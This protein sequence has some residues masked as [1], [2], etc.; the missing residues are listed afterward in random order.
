VV[1]PNN[2]PTETANQRLQRMACEG[3]DESRLL[4]SRRG[5]LGVTAG[6]FSWAF[7]PR[8]AEASSADPRLVVVVLRG[9]MD[10][11]TTVVPVGDPQ[12]V[13]KRGALA[14][15]AAS[16]IRLNSF[17]GLH[18]TLVN[19]GKFYA[20]GDA[21]VVHAT[22]VPFHN[23]SHF[24]GQDNLESGLPGLGSNETGWLNRL[25][26]ALPAGAPI[27]TKGAIEIGR[28]PLILRGPAPV[29]GWSPSH[30]SHM[31]D[32]LLTMVRTLYKAND[33]EL[34]TVLDRGLKADNLAEG[35]GIDD[36]SESAMILGFRGAGR[37]VASPTGPRIAV[38]SVDGWDTHLNQG[39]VD[40][41]LPELLSDLDAGLGAFR[42]AVG[43]AWAQTVV[44]MVT[45]FGR[46]ARINGDQGTDHGTATV[47]LLAGGAVKG[48]RVIA[49]W[50][51]LAA[52]DL[53]EGR[54]LMPT[55]DL[56]SVFKGILRDH[57]DV[58]QTITNSKV[59]P[60]SDIAPPL[61]GL[62]QA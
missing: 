23:R 44:V 15:P 50:P 1:V 26:T 53:F 33:P 47:T 46:T 43:A 16:T 5:M 29:L 11:L 41:K 14:I 13:G 61:A 39:D 34:L 32:P 19:F 3:C 42:A 17:F 37:L 48:G 59:F 62:I 22:C 25:L 24:D 28:T 55:T 10:G 21:A 6:L 57:L 49:D 30:F 36:G 31:Q 51:G 60:N 52:A 12:Y 9:G 2:H 58:P 4:L 38:L 40:G 7:I 8:D 56:R 54:D 45:E 20:A 27:K 18:P 35:L